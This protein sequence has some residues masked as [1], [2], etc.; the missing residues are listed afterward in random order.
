MDPGTVI[1][2]SSAPVLNL[3]P[4]GGSLQSN[5]SAAS[6]VAAAASAA[7]ATANYQRHSWGNEGGNEVKKVS[8]ALLQA[9]RCFHSC[10]CNLP[11]AVLG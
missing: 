7:A 5:P 9:C 3:P 1:T 11:A 10:C 6:G 8:E 4:R 2:P